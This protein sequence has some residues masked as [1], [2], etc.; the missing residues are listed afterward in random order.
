MLLCHL[1]Q[2]ESQYSSPV[3]VNF[4]GAGTTPAKGDR[5]RPSFSAEK[6]VSASSG[7][8][9]SIVE[10]DASA[11]AEGMGLDGLHRLAAGLLIAFGSG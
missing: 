4:D 1:L 3:F 2:C 5:C 8:V 9:F 11:C 7:P 10:L 6:L